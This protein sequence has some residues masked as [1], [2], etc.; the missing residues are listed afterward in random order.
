MTVEEFAGFDFAT[1]PPLPLLVSRPAWLGWRERLHRP[2][3]TRRHP[4]V[5]N[6]KLYTTREVAA[7]M[8]VPVTQV[9]SAIQRGQLEAVRVGKHLRVSEAAINRF[10]VL[11][12]TTI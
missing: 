7:Y 4:P 1:G 6:Q 10:L 9:Y 11:H 12:S 8:A 2:S 5:G 3:P